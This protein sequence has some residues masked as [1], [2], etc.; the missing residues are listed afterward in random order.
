MKLSR[1][2]RQFVHNGDLNRDSR[3]SD[4]IDSGIAVLQSG[5]FASI[6]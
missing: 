5:I 1:S 2:R 3:T 6:V 4:G